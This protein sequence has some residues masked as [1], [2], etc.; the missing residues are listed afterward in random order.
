MNL[1]KPKPLCYAADPMRGWLWFLS[2]IVSTRIGPILFVAI[3]GAGVWILTR[4]TTQSL[5]LLRGKVLDAAA[6]NAAKALPAGKPPRSLAVLPFAGDPAQQVRHALIA[7]FAKTKGQ[8][9]LAPGGFLDRIELE[10]AQPVDSLAE[11]LKAASRLNVDAVAFGQV[12]AF[13]ARENEAEIALELCVADRTTGGAAVKQ[14]FVERTHG[15][16]DAIRPRIADRPAIPR[17]AGWLAVTVLLPL[18]LAVPIRRVLERESNRANFAVLAG[19]TATSAVAAWL[20]TGFAGGGWTSLGM[21]AAAAVAGVS[22][23]RIV[24]WMERLR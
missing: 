22:N 1:C 11:A 21:L 15:G 12:T 5:G 10:T 7:A 14:R 20:L 23:F 6:A 8:Y 18:I 13:T 16:F 17:V 4:P 19:L 24:S 3:C 2:R 9:Q